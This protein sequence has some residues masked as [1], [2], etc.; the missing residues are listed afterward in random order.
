LVGARRA[1]RPLPPRDWAPPPPGCLSFGKAP[2]LRLAAFGL[3]VALPR[4]PAMRLLIVYLFLLA[5]LSRPGVPAWACVLRRA[6]LCAPRSP[7]PVYSGKARARLCACVMR[8]ASLCLVC[9]A[10]TRP[11]LLPRVPGAVRHLLHPH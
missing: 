11:V 2:W 8:R 9:V 1:P 4:R 10:W 3:R 6:A 7:C 5:A